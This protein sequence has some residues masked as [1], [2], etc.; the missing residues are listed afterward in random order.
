[1]KANTEIDWTVLDR[2][3]AIEA[4]LEA[5]NSLLGRLFADAS[6]HEAAIIRM[7]TTLNR[8]SWF[9]RL[10]FAKWGN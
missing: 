9:K 10:F 4:R 6:R 3:E 8:P 5:Q 2:I 1:M 7:Q